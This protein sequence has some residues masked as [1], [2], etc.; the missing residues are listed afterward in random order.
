[1]LPVLAFAGGH[2]GSDHHTDSDR[3]RHIPVVPEANAGWVL[4]PFLVRFCSFLGDSFLAL[5]QV[6][7]RIALKP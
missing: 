2:D 1:M 7:S 5:R 4:V 6:P 3:D